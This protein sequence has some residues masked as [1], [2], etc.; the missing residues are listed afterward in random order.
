MLEDEKY[1]FEEYQEITADLAEY[2]SDITGRNI[3]LGVDDNLDIWLASNR[4]H[5][6]E[7]FDSIAEATRRVEL[8][9]SDLLFDDGESEDLEGF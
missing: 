5:G 6:K 8:L 2:Y 9:Y 1:T 3:I 4:T 7:Y